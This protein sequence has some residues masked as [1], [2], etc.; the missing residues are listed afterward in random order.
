MST[1][2]I[3]QARHAHAAACYSDGANGEG[4]PGSVIVLPAMISAVTGKI[5]VDLVC[6]LCGK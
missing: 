5:V 2:R 4:E 3:P 1:T 6:A